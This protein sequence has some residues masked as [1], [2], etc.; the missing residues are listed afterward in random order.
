MP[1]RKLIAMTV[2]Q[3]TRKILA[4]TET[5][6]E[7]GFRRLL[8]HAHGD[9]KILEEAWA[10]ALAEVEPGVSPPATKVLEYIREILKARVHASA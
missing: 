10:M 5:D 9:R 8:E 7:R 6:E 3:L 1:L 2:K 4:R